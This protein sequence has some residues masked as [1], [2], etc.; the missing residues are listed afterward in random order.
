MAQERLTRQELSWLL[1]QEARG[2]AKA[3][4]EGV[5]HISQPGPKV[6]TL[7]DGGGVRTSLDALDDAIGM[8]SELQATRSGT[9]RGRIDLA[10]L[11]CD[12]APSARIAMA[13]GAGTE[14]FGDE[15]DLRRMLHVLLSQSDASGGGPAAPEVTIR[16]SQDEVQISVELGPDASPTAALERRWLNRMALRYGGRF[17]LDGG[18]QTMWLPADGA[19]DQREVAELRKELKQAQQLGEIYARELATLMDSSSEAVED[20]SAEDRPSQLGFVPDGEPAAERFSLLVDLCNALSRNLKEWLEPLRNDAN[21][22]AVSLDRDS[23][24][25]LDLNQRVAAGYDT[26]SMLNLFA[27]TKPGEKKQKL[28][29]HQELARALEAAEPRALRRGVALES[30][31]LAIERCSVTASPTVLLALLQSLLHH[32]IAAT[33]RGDKV[34]ASASVVDQVIRVQIEDGGPSIPPRSRARLALHRVDPTSLGRPTG[35]SLLAAATAAK[36]VGGNLQLGE[37]AAKRTCV[38]LELPSV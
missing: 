8:L 36:F 28:D 25:G 16:R 29:L 1:A 11:L 3:L 4:R 26:L 9:R 6:E 23:E 32:A 33:P 14:V 5:T 13:P 38:I 22:L 35:I 18:T 7:P 17:E 12:V 19:S 27:S 10:A 37:S 34:T 24:L 30:H 20:P 2:A 31:S 21:Q 15:N